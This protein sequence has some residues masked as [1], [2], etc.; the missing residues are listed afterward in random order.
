MAVVH[1]ALPKT[2][3]CPP[4]GGFCVDCPLELLQQSVD[5]LLEKWEK[6]YYH[7]SSYGSS[8]K[9]KENVEAIFDRL[10]PFSQ[11]EF[12]ILLPSTHVPRYEEWIVFQILPIFQIQSRPTNSSKVVAYLEVL[13]LR[14]IDHSSA[15]ASRTTALDL[16]IEVLA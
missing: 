9:T 10:N 15:S 1:H 16:L 13:K 4:D 14:T 11:E 2:H 7:P 5:Q 3:T 12:S 6:F 8:E